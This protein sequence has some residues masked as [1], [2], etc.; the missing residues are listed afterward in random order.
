MT[1]IPAKQK[2][3]FIR[4]Q[5]K[6]SEHLWWRH[7]PRRRKCAFWLCY[8]TDR[9]GFIK[10]LNTFITILYGQAFANSLKSIII[11]LLRFMLPVLIS[12]ECFL[13][14]CEGCYSPAF[15]T[16]ELFSFPSVS[17][18]DGG[19]ALWWLR[20]VEEDQR[21]RNLLSAV[22]DFLVVGSWRHHKCS[23]DF[24]CY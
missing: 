15:I 4:I 24:Y 17:K 2:N 11:L 19:D 1:V 6:S 23:E 5:A 21:R 18:P 22:Y 13:I 12:S 7:E 20:C 10:S 8:S 16:C 3:F 9:W 14:T